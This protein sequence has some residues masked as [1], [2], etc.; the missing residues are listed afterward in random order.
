MQEDTAMLR[1]EVFALDAEPDRQ[2]KNAV[3]T[4]AIALKPA[5]SRLVEKARCEIT[6]FHE[7]SVR[8]IDLWFAE[9]ETAATA[10]AIRLLHAQT[11]SGATAQGAV[12][13]R[14]NLGIGSSIKDLR[15]GRSTTRLA[16]FFRGQIEMLSHQPAEPS[17]V[18]TRP[19]S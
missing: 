18:T 6:A 13:R 9:E 16:Q 11:Q 7:P 2:F 10:S 3:E 12:V 17:A 19:Q 14:Y 8:S 5:R 1:V 4:K 15:T